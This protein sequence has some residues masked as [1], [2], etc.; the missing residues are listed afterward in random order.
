MI[1]DHIGVTTSTL[2]AGRTLLESSVGVQAWTAP[3]EDSLNQVWVQF[4]HDASG[5]CYELVA[6]L[7]DRSPVTQVLSQK[8]NVLNHVA[9]RVPDLAAHAARLGQAGFAQVAPARPAIAYAGALIQFFVS[10]NRLL[11]EL[12]E[13]P[14]HQHRYTR[15]E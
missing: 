9:Y 6:P 4:G 5:I 3:F 10:R 12:I 15:T 11:I 7:S 1:F 8:I 2:D 13:A 14:D